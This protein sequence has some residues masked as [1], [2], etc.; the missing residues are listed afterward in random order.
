[1][2]ILFLYS[3]SNKIVTGGQFYE[4]NLYRIFAST[5][6]IET[7]RIFLDNIKTKLDRR[8]APLR[9]LCLLPSLR[10][11]DLVIF[12]SAAFMSFQPL[13]RMLKLAGVKTAVVHHHFLY[14]QFEG[15]KRKLYKFLE[16]R[17]L[18]T[19]DTIIVP[20]PYIN[21]EVRRLF[22]KKRV[23]YWQIP[24]KRPAET[25][26]MHPKPGNLL[27]IG[28]IE[29]RKGLLYLVDAMAMLKKRG[30]PCSLKI[31]GKTVEAD[32]KE[33]LD[34]VIA[35]NNLDV[36]YTGFIDKEEM[37]HITSEAD[38]F[39]FPSMLEGYGMAICESLVKGLP[40]V[41][42]NNSAMPFT[43]EDNVNGFLVENRNT[44]AFADSLAHIITDRPLRDRL[45]Q[46]ALTTSARLM[47]PARFD[48]TVR[49]DLP[50][51]LQ[52]P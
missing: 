24:F 21:Q 12:N 30:I 36:I 42:F 10:K 11:Y 44:Q 47:T 28:T 13:A 51:L 45:S 22:P 18:R 46:G 4:D 23:I 16:Y 49:H 5:P 2:K 6:D 1:M 29:R 26:E 25:L 50:T 41:C 38:I 20:S 3:G 40:V 43:V 37:D 8:T 15:K 31:I 35:D 32:Y 27:Y 14:M 34:K 9:N 39:A 7:D 19:V 48:H 52:H 17:F 33:Q